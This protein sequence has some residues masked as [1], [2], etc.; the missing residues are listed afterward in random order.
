MRTPDSTPS[1]ASR[2]RRWRHVAL[3]LAAF[4]AAMWVTNAAYFYLGDV[5]RG[6]TGTFLPRLIEELTGAVG[7]ALL[8]PLL[9]WVSWRWPIGRHSWARHLPVHI[10]AAVG[11][12]VAHTTFNAVTRALLFPAFGLGAYDYGDMHIRYWMEMPRDLF[13]Y[14]MIA[15]I[16]H[17]FFAYR[18]ARDHE[19][20]AA[21]LESRLAQAQLQNLRLQLQPHFL[22]NA[23]NTISSVMY[24]DTRAADTMIGKLGE[25]LRHTLRAPAAQET[26][27]A[28]EL[29]A[30]GLYIDLMRARF[31][32]RLRVRVRAEPGTERALV[33]QLIL[34][35][36]V[37]NALHHG[38]D[39]A[40]ACGDVEV[41]ARRDNGDLTLEV[42]DHGAG[43]RRP[44]AEAL[45]GGIGLSNTAAR[46]AQLYG[47]G[48]RLD[49]RD[50]PGGGLLVTITIPFRAAG[51]DASPAARGAAGA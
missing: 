4:A 16:A 1:P 28:E 48:R 17:L 10:V 51:S 38:L 11:G 42:R 25:L 49:L 27:L 13:M 33:P 6:R 34:Q 29:D 12:S 36:L 3:L 31:E 43:L 20:R 5:V 44:A 39:P 45:R 22:F 46:L 26:T 37:E 15:G 7:G 14:A 23:L 30:L 24:E 2:R 50:A 41:R 21:R 18:A 8:V 9:L 19:V 47:E 35:P 40:T 32:D